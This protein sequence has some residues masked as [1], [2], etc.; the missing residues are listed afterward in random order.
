[1]L[2]DFKA[3]PD[4]L[5]H[6]RSNALMSAARNGHD[7]VV[8]MLVGRT[9]DLN[10]K[11]LSGYTAL[12]SAAFVG[13]FDVVVTLV[14]NDADVNVVNRSRKTPMDIAKERRHQNIFEFLVNQTKTEAVDISNR[15]AT[16]P[17]QQGSML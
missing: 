6:S 7:G 5:D 12:A 17:T 15:N 14:L 16:T 11:N 13:H 9:N 8:K 2:I 3:D 1:M 4:L 10:A